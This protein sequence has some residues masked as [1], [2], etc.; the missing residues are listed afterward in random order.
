MHEDPLD[1]SDSA[2]AG[3]PTHLLRLLDSTAD[4]I[5]FV[6]TDERL[7]YQNQAA[8]DAVNG[9]DWR[10]KTL[11]ELAVLLASP[12]WAEQVR[13]A[14]HDGT[15]LQF[16]WYAPRL[17]RWMTQDVYPVMGGAALFG[18]DV[19]ARHEQDLARRYDH[20]KL[21]HLARHD[22]LTGLPNRMALH[23]MIDQ[24]LAR[25]GGPNFA[26]HLI[27]LDGFKAINDTLGHAI[28]D[29]LLKQVAA[30]LRD[31]Q[32]ADDTVARYGGDEFVLLQSGGVQPLEAVATGR[33]IIAALS[34]PYHIE[35]ERIQ[36]GAC[37][38]I[39]FAPQHGSDADGLFRAADA[40]MYQAK[41][42][43]R[44]NVCC[45]D[46]SIQHAKHR[47]QALRAWMREAIGNQ[48]LH[49]VFQPL[50]TLETGLAT[51]FEALLRWRQPVLGDIGPEEF[52]P[53]AEESGQ[54]GAIGAWALQHA[55]REA[56]TWPSAFS[57]TVN[58]SPLQLTPSIVD[59]VA[60]ALRESRLAPERLKLEITE[61]VLLE[62]SASNLATLHTLRGMGVRI[63]LDDFGVGFASL[64]YLQQFPFD[65]IKIDRSFVNDLDRRRDSQ[66]IVKA[67]I[68]L[69]DDMGMATTA[70]GVETSG[71]L[72][73]LRQA[74]CGQVQGFL[75]GRPMAASE[76]PGYLLSY[77]AATDA[78][79]SATD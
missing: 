75:L 70:E 74:G 43:G 72:D 62:N 9:A 27:D 20:Q 69:A 16:D 31:C 10:G 77:L 52:I 51:E 5:G 28:G 36:V 73:W 78:A 79:D 61:S 41:A 65:K 8:R 66:A 7:R 21:T 18:R 35:R 40:A 22:A 13:K 32:G 25:S 17:Q 55:C 30:R 68:L 23:A 50:I 15:H 42:V 67:V 12:A 11:A 3:D 38:G 24:E 54:I 57:V 26:L 34:R 4:Y 19:T 2:W 63:V 47:R 6:G 64:S 53:I 58:L 33:R 46:P 14:L 71:Q 60:S 1:R 44:N 76:L 49:L 45:F 59:T 29:Q 56:A 39:A 48:E 37:I